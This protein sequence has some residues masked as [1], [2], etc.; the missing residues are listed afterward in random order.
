MIDTSN[1]RSL[2]KENT[3]LIK[4]SLS[5]L[6]S[7]CEEHLAGFEQALCQKNTVSMGGNAHSLKSKLAYLGHTAGV[8]L[9]KEIESEAKNNEKIS[10]SLSQKSA[11]FILLVND[12]INMVT[13]EI[14]TTN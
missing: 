13:E 6:K 1:L 5:L 14:K 2:L 9:A 4:Q 8:A 12:V 3:A 7:S 11:N 10:D